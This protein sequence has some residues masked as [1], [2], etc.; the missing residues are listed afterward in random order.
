MEEGDA[1]AV[2]T[3]PRH[4]VDETKARRPAALRHA[5][6]DMMNARPAPG[7]KLRDRAARIAGLEQLDLDV[8]QAY[9][10]DRRTVDGLGSSRLEAEN[11]PVKAE[12]G[13]DGRNGDADVGDAGGWL[14]HGARQHNDCTR[15]SGRIWKR[16][17][18]RPLRTQ[19]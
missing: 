19:H 12:G 4:I 2:G 16:N 10:D 6:A 1:A 13:V 5:V 18:S 15:G 9:G 11:V 8:A 17:I 3:D 14:A 7:E